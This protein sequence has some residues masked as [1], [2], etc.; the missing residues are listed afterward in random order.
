M[1]TPHLSLLPKA[2]SIRSCGPKIVFRNEK[3]KLPALRFS[4]LRA[5][6]RAQSIDGDDS[7][8]GTGGKAGLGHFLVRIDDEVCRMNNFASIFPIRAHLVGGIRDL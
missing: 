8:D 5:S 4:F 2:R 3:L 6:N 7:A 1:A